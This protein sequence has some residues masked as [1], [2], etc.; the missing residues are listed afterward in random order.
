MFVWYWRYNASREV[1]DQML[2]KEN[3]VLKSTSNDCSGVREGLNVCL[4]KA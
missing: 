4:Q 3:E 2:S 1:L